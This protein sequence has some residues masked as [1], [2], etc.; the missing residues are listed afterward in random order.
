MKVSWTRC[1]SQTGQPILCQWWNLMVLCL[2]LWGL[3]THCPQSLQAGSLYPTL[4]P[5]SLCHIVGRTNFHKLDMRSAFQ[6][7]LTWGVKGLPCNQHI[8]VFTVTTACFSVSSA[9]WIFRQKG[10]GGLAPWNH[11]SRCVYVH[12][13]HPGNM[14]DCRRA[15]ASTVTRS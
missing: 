10:H 4:H 15:S 1:S 9:S 5:G 6:Q 14:K 3:Q 2:N 13:W 8:G 7:L 12:R 11:W